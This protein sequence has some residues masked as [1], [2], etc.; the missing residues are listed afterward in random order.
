MY[1]NKSKFRKLPQSI[2]ASNRAVFLYEKRQHRIIEKLG[3]LTFFLN[4]L[5]LSAPHTIT[6][7]SCEAMGFF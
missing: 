2:T 4:L 7:I 1:I 6:Y 5:W 3:I